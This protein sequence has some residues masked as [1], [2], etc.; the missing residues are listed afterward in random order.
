ME[1]LHDHH[2]SPRSGHR[3]KKKKEKKKGE[4]E[5]RLVHVYH[6]NAWLF[7]E[8]PVYFSSVVL[9]P[10]VYL[11]LNRERFSEITYSPPSSTR[12]GFV[13]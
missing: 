10:K 3:E 4:K 13:C 2:V 7:Y 6:R 9:C 8:G 12:V 5:V 11:V 1:P